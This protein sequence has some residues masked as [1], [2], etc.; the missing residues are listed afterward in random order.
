MLSMI[1]AAGRRGE[2][3]RHG[4]MI[5]HLPAD[6]RHFKR[7]TTGAPVIMGRKTWE[8]LPKRPLPARLN[9]VITH[10]D[11]YLAPGAVIATSLA[12]AIAAASPPL[13][14]EI[15]IIG[16]AEIYR[17]AYPLA[18]RI[19]LTAIHDEAPDAD[20]FF[21]LPSPGDWIQEH[22]PGPDAPSDP[23]IEFLLYTRRTSP[24]D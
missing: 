4:A 21:P 11:G 20:T 10:R 16:G 23:P 1:V 19:Y 8:S 12:E 3:G 6:L 2:I 15:F 22:L 18:S 5:W 9:I 7:I 24:P 14:N 17:Q 13:H